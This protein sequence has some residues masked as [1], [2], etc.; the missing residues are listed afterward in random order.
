MSGHPSAHHRPP[1]SSRIRCPMEPDCSK[2]SENGP[3]RHQSRQ[4]MDSSAARASCASPAAPVAQPLVRHVHTTAP[5]S[6]RLNFA[7]PFPAPLLPKNYPYVGGSGPNIIHRCLGPRRQT[8]ARSSQSLLYNTHRH[9]DRR[10]YTE[11][12]L[13]R[14]SALYAISRSNKQICPNSFGNRPRCHS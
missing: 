13:Y 9:T 10:D 8:A 1:A 11:I 7:A 3:R 5:H 14:Q 12:D 2:E 6:M 4:R